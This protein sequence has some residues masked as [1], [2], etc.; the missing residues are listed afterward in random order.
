LK[1][2]LGQKVFKY[3]LFFSDWMV[4]HHFIMRLLLLVA[5]I[6]ISMSLPIDK[7]IIT[8]EGIFY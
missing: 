3:D 4:D 5:Y 2:V 6:A 7:E 1:Y 8:E